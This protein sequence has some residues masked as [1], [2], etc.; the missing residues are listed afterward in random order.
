[1]GRM[2]SQL[3]PCVL[4]S[5]ETPLVGS[6][7]SLVGESLIN[8]GAKFRAVSQADVPGDFAASV[9]DPVARDV[10]GFQGDAGFARA[11]RVGPFDFVFVDESLDVLQTG[12][13]FSGEADEDDTL[14]RVL[15]VELHQVRHSRV[16]LRAPRRPAIDDN[17]FALK[18]FRRRKGAVHRA[19]ASE[20]RQWLPDRQAGVFGIAAADR[21][22][23]RG[24]SHDRSRAQEQAEGLRRCLAHAHF[25]F[26]MTRLAA[27]H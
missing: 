27:A 7:L 24:A 6:L 26:S 23:K 5:D 8:R 3:M 25:I 2:L 4:G 16:A 17:D 14:L 1:M 9:E 20:C 18:V 22:Q 11:V 15:F 10:A 19:R 21:P 12:F 13:V